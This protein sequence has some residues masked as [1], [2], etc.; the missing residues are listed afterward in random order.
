MSHELLTGEERGHAQ[1]TE[2]DNLAL[3]RRA[4]EAHR[5]VVGSARTALEQALEAGRA[6]LE[7]K[8]RCPHRGWKAWVADH[9]EG[10]L[11]T[12]QRYVRLAV[13]WP[14]W[15]VEA[16]RVSPISHNEAVRLLAKLAERD[17]TPAAAANR[18]TTEPEHPALPATAEPTPSSV[19]Q[20]TSLAVSAAIQPAEISEA[21]ARLR[22]LAGLLG[23]RLD[24]LE[25]TIDSQDLGYGHHDDV[26][27]LI[28]QLQ[29]LWRDIDAWCRQFA[30]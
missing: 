4:N 1:S 23:D 8:Q 21:Q 25:Q 11:R 14:R 7:A 2:L 29:G 3:A 17:H 28:D 26:E 9:F 12:A 27:Y 24:E 20:P 30:C 22:S 15:G 5:Q 10:S 18:A 19:E 16:T 13:N 6:L